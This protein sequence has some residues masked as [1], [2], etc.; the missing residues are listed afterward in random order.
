M[1]LPRRT[2][3]KWSGVAI[4]VAL[5]IPFVLARRRSVPKT[6]S[7]DPK[8]VLDLAAGLSYR[9]LSRTGES[10]AD[11]YRV[12]GLPDGM[13][14]FARG[15]DRLVLMRNHEIGR[16][17]GQGAARPGQKPP[18]EAFD[19]SAHGGVTRVVLDAKSGKKLSENL[20][21]TGTLR[22]CAGGTS[23]WGWLSCEESME[24]GHGYVFLCRPEA[25]SVRAPEQ[26]LGY[27]R[28]NHEA[29]VVDP[30]SL[31]AY[32]S[33]DR[34][35]S[36]LYRFVPHSPQHPFRGKLQAMRLVGRPRFNT[37][38]G[39]KLG[40][41]LAVDWVDIPQ[42]NPKQDTVRKQAHKLGAAKIR[43]GEGLAWHRGTLYLVSTTGGAA[44]VGQIFSL[45]PAEGKFALL[46]ES[47][48]E[49]ALDCPDNI[50]VAPWGDIVVAEDGSGDQLLRGITP[51]GR[52]YDIARNAGSRGELA[53]V[54]FF[55]DGST[56]FLNL[57]REGLTLAIRGDV[58][59]ARKRA[60]PMA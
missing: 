60:R 1:A 11:G 55:P 29:A 41:K 8:G 27:G 56:L 24:A 42:P 32:L 43:R 33:E 26:L 46:A 36:C 54:C 12:P 48:G 15:K 5:P 57:Q 28:M 44:G 6:L 58:K 21:L 35:D 53:G 14:C 37:S 17:L 25:A 4:A 23:P 38:R 3:L 7:A 52:V 31:V 45:D 59:A 16:Y 19:P 13:A 10:M 18:K 20:V 22:N 30:K 40:E 51:E 2:L 34:S 47:P 50:T 9:V 39:M 49:S